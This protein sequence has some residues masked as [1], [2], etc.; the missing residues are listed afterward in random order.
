MILLVTLTVLF[1]LKDSSWERSVGWVMGSVLDPHGDFLQQ[2]NQR[3]ILACVV[4]VSLDPLF[5]YIPVIDGQ[6][7][8]LNLDRP[9]E[10]TACVLRSL[11]DIVYLLHIIFQFRTAYITPSL[12]YGPDKLVDNPK[13]IAK[14]YLST[15]FVI[16]ILAILPLPQVCMYIFLICLYAFNKLNSQSSSY[17]KYIQPME[18]APFWDWKKQKGE[19]KSMP[20]D[21]SLIFELY[22]VYSQCKSQLIRNELW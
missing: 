2:W 22:N 4:S 10:I 16:D 3:F 5:L 6:R 7:K 21:S 11:T 15:Y 1:R 19:L 13:A 18:A 20:H 9:L 8:C 14:R 12:L 17:F